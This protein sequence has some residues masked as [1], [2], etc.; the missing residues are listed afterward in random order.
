MTIPFNKPYISGKEFEYMHDAAERGHLSGNGYYT[1]KCH[2]FFEERWG[3]TNCF[4]TTSCT[5][6][7]EMSALLLDIKPGDEVIVPSYTFVSTALAIDS[8]Y[9]GRPLGGIGHLGCFSFHETKGIQCGE[10]GMLSVNDERLL[11]RAEIIWE[12]GTD[13]AAFF[14]GEIDKYG[15]VDMGSSFQPPELIAAFLYAQLE[16]LD[17]IQ[18]RR[19]KLW[20]T[21]F[22]NLQ[23]LAENGLINVPAIPE[24]ASNNAHAFYFI[25]RSAE[26]RTELIQFLKDSGIQAAFHYQGLHTSKYFNG[27]KSVKQLLFSDR[28]TDCLVRLPLY[29]QL[30]ENEIFSVSDH[31]TNFYQ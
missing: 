5:D 15:W 21:Y 7:L 10:G 30:A 12:K 8:F 18:N 13:R 9:K 14:R 2:A 6:A 24:Y 31:I 3:L 1:K 4:L 25:C 27:D 20:N 11:K 17:E 23:P 16:K 22:E 29:Y 19:L 26:E 28:Y